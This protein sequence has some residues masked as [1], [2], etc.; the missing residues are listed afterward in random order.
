MIGMGRV[1]AVLLRYVQDGQGAHIHA[2]V[3]IGQFQPR[4]HA[5]DQRALA[6][7]CIADEAD[8]A[9]VGAQVHLP[10]LH[11]KVVHTCLAAGRE[12]GCLDQIA[13]HAV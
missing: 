12:I 2:V 5:V 7:A 4:E 11:A 10:H 1:E 8:Q 6:R 3:I 9:V 13:L